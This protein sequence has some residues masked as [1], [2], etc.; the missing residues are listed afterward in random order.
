VASS[1]VDAIVKKGGIEETRG[2]CLETEEGVKIYTVAAAFA[3]G[4]VVNTDVI[5]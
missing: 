1:G 4:N 2:A 3:E 5:T